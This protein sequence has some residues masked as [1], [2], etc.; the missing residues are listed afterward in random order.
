[1]NYPHAEH[2]LT[3]FLCNTFPLELVGIWD[4]PE[5]EPFVCPEW[6]GWRLAPESVSKE[7]AP[8]ADGRGGAKKGRQRK[9][10]QGVLQEEQR[11]SSGTTEGA[12]PPKRAQRKGKRKVSEEEERARV[13]ETQSSGGLEALLQ[14]EQHDVATPREGEGS[15]KD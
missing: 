14:K 7:S 15:Q 1:M 2:P 11:S 4:I 9:T 10:Q 6:K 13:Q 5:G 3:L 8:P 12:L